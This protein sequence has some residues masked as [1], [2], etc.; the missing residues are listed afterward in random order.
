MSDAEYGASTGALADIRDAALQV[1]S[2]DSPVAEI[3]PPAIDAE[4]VVAANE[5][6]DPWPT[7]LEACA[8]LLQGMAAARGAAGGSGMPAVALERDPV[9][10]QASVRLPLPDALALRQLAKAFE[11]WLHFR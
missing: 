1:A 6:P 10:G 7:L 3:A 9:T 4:A 8:A 11:P 2:P 5:A